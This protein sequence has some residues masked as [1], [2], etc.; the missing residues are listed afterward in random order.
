MLATRS[1]TKVYSA[2]SREVIGCENIDLEIA[3]GEFVVLQGRSGAGKTTLLNLLGGLDRPTRGQVLIDGGDL[4]ALSESELTRLRGRDIGY[5]FQSFGL[6]P[7]LS[8]AENVEVPLRIQRTDPAERDERVAETLRLVGLSRQSAQR[9]A[10]LSGGQQQRVGLARAIVSRPRL[11]I[12]D[13]PTAQLDSATAAGIIEL[14]DEMV[15]VQ[16][17]AAI[18]STHH[19]PMSVRASRLLEIRDGRLVPS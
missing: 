1:V 6:L 2:G 12:A 15:Q 10:E 14:I 3:A 17:M 4:A 5:V 7:M 11:L 13:E 18:V 19:A 8:A 16:G 9:P